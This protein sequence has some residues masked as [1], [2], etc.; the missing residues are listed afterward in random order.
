MKDDIAFRQSRSLGHTR[1]HFNLMTALAEWAISDAGG[2]RAVFGSKP[3][4]APYTPTDLTT[5]AG[6]AAKGNLANMPSI[7]DFLESVLPGYGEMVKTGSK[8]TLSLLR[9]EI[10]EDVQAAIKR[11]SAFKSLQG[12]YGGSGM[13]KALTIRDLGRTSLDLQQLGGSAAARWAG[14]TQ[15]GVAPFTV[16]APAQADATFRNNLYSQATEQ[17]KLNTAAAPDPG[18][19]G[20]FN[21]QTALGSQAMSFG[22][23]SAAGA[24]G[25]SAQRPQANVP[26]QQSYFSGNAT[27]TGSGMGGWQWGSYW[28]GG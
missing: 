7:R 24:M 27:N 21:L 15:A 9:G 5:E 20:Q 12:G 8:S 2:S 1:Q 10:P 4:T 19:A 14:L 6:R 18:A 25:G 17:F 23:G 3:G 26:Q 11:S 22:L 28:G 13:S 16:T